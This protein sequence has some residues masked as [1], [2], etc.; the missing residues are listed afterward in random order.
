MTWPREF[1]LTGETMSM[2]EYADLLERADDRP[3]EREERPR[4]R[5]VEGVLPRSG[6]RKARRAAAAKARRRG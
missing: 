3:L 2:A 4:H 1:G 6:N 5:V